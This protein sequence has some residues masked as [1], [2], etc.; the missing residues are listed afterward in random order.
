MSTNPRERQAIAAID[1]SDIDSK[2]GVPLTEAQKLRAALD[3]VSVMEQPGMWVLFA[4]D[5]LG[6]RDVLIEWANGN[7]PD[8]YIDRE[9]KPGGEF[10]IRRTRDH[11]AIAKWN[12]VE[13]TP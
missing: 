7:A 2:P 1:F 11:K 12:A 5:G 4:S 9:V 10:E 3:A 13:V 8:V 6:P